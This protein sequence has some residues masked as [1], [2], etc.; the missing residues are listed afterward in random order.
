ME[1]VAYKFFSG[2]PHLLEISVHREACYEPW[3]Q[4]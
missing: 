1:Y 4:P 2:K 3:S